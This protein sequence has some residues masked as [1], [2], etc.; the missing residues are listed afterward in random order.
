MDGQTRRIYLVRGRNETVPDYQYDHA[1]AEKLTTC[2]GTNELV[3]S[4]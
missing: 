3:W 2:T 4:V 1:K